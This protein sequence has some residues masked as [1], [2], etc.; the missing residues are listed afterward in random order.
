MKGS[1]ALCSHHAAGRDHAI[2]RPFD[3]A[4]DL[5]RKRIV[6]EAQVQHEELKVGP[7][8][9]RF[10]TGL[11]SEL[12]GMIAFAEHPVKD[13]HGFFRFG[14]PVGRRPPEP[15]APDPRVVFSDGTVSETW[16]YIE[17]ESGPIGQGGHASSKEEST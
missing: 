15:P 17:L 1:P 12:G 13:G 7:A 14:G 16:P 4:G 11:S 8:T 5:P 3:L 9:E 2:Q 10:Q 6:R